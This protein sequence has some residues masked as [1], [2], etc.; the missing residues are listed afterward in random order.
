MRMKELED[1][2]VSLQCS[3]ILLVMFL[4]NK[5][6]YNTFI[7]HGGGNWPMLPDNEKINGE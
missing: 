7:H 3:A 2:N 4:G 6:I 1:L 5:G